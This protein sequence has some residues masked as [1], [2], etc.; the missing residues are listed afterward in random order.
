MYIFY[1]IDYVPT[2]FVKTEGKEIVIKVCEFGGRERDGSSMG[3]S[4]QNLS[5]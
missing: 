3:S 4:N 1:H 2:D 5:V